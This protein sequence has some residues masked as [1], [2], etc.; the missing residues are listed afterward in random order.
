ME[1]GSKDGERNIL[2]EQEGEEGSMKESVCE[3]RAGN[4]H[5]SD[6]TQSTPLSAKIMRE[7]EG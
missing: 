1:V 7:S 4:A 3:I 6:G 5:G 2:S